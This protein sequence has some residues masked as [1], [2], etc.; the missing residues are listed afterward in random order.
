M[1]FW[2]KLSSST[3]V[4]NFEIY[5]VTADKHRLKMKETNINGWRLGDN[6]R[7]HRYREKLYPNGESYQ[8]EFVNGVRD[9]HGKLVTSG[10]TKIYT[11]QFVNGLYHG[12]GTIE[13]LPCIEHNK[14][15]K[16]R[17]FKG[18]FHRGIREGAGEYHDEIGNI[19]MGEWK[20]DFFTGEGILTKSNGEHYEGTWLKGNLHC[21]KATIKYINGDSYDGAMVYGKRHGEMGYLSYS[22]GQGSYVG[23]FVNGRRHGIGTRH[24]QDKWY[25]G[26]FQ[27]NEIAGEGNMHYTSDLGPYHQ[28]KGQW[29][30]GV[31]HGKGELVFKKKHKVATT[32][33]G[34]F[35]NGYMHGHGIIHYKN[36]GLYEGEFVSPSI[37]TTSFK[38]NVSTFKDIPC[39]GNRHGYGIRVWPSGNKFEGT[40]EDD[41]MVQGLFHDVKACSKYNGLFLN[42]MKDGHG[43][44]VWHSPNG[45]DFRDPCL[46]WIH[47]GSGQ[48]QYEGD[49]RNGLF[50]GMGKFVSPDGRSYEGEWKDGKQ[51]GKGN[52]TLLGRHERGNAD[53]MHIGRNGSLYR[54]FQYT[55]KWENGVRQGVGEI[56]YLGGTTK[57]GV[58][59]DGAWKVES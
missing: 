4:S 33:T 43:R 5:G 50:H 19:W 1:S 22:K 35:Q 55:G 54:P 14:P 59:D 3:L 2:Q 25:R 12:P 56:L 9:G 45:K 38:H 16:G 40:W 23:Q 26:E 58:F 31:F 28:Y 39:V 51:N 30:N 20:N 29:L 8:G 41:Q 49:Y 18:V 57:K 44:E 42:N 32:Y 37:S 7:I 34:S 10:G 13:W 15:I 36:G 48:C 24:F 47:R 52:A 11:G 27:D 46:G 53:K 6:G 17:K 21:E